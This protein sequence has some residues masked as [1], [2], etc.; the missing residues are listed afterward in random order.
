[1]IVLAVLTVAAAPGQGW[2][3]VAPVLA[4][5]IGA[6][7][8]VDV[9]ILRWRGGAW[10]F[11]SGALLTG[12]IAAMVMSA[13][14]PPW[15]VAVTSAIG[16]LSKYV[17]RGRTANV[18]NPAALAIVV[19]F[20]AFGT[21]QSWWGALPDAPTWTLLLLVGTGV[22]IT[23]R[24]NK[25]PLVLAFL[26]VFY[27]LFTATAF[28]GDAAGVAEVYRTPDVQAALFFACFILTDPPTSP[29][30]YRAQIICGVLVGVT[31]FVVYETVGA[32]HYLLAGVL[33]GNV[34][35]AWNRR[36]R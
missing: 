35:E 15:V 2:T 6:A 16:V 22:F 34:W 8:L 25:F 19:T 31:A 13:H 17:V 3:L 24:V 20:Y 30:R 21:G 7:A 5:G 4:A 33:V 9:W 26:G 23:D 10:T 36:R 11:P 27:L 29:T 14:E 28:A 12:W 32:V 1:V 18:F